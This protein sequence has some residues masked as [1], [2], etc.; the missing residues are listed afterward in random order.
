M[1][2][3]SMRVLDPAQGDLDPTRITDL[4]TGK[5][6]EVGG[7]GMPL[8]QCSAC[9]FVFNVAADPLD[10]GG[11]FIRCPNCSTVLAR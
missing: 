2:Q 11:R 1:K 3:T 8:Y 7:R 5:E 4:Q 6:P 10:D 9:R